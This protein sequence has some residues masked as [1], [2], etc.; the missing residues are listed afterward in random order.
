MCSQQRLVRNRIQQWLSTIGMLG[1]IK[2]RIKNWWQK[3]RD[4]GGGGGKRLWLS[5]SHFFSV[6]ADIQPFKQSP[7]FSPGSLILAFLFKSLHPPILDIQQHGPGCYRWRD[8][9]MWGKNDQKEGR[10]LSINSWKTYSSAR[11]MF[12]RRRMYIKCGLGVSS[13]IWNHWK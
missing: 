6:S 2:K 9:R 13:F 3:D 12:V 10:T 7:L 11:R 8:W 1:F 4:W 5:I